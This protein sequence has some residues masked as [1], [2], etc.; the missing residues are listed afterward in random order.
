MKTLGSRARFAA[1]G[2]LAVLLLAAGASSPL[3]AEGYDPMLQIT[4]QFARPNIYLVVDVSGSMAWDIRG[5]SVGVDQTGTVPTAAWSSTR[6]SC[7]DSKCKVWTYTLTV[8]QTWPS[9][10]ATLKNALGDSVTIVTPWQEPLD[11]LTDTTYGYITNGSWKS[12]GTITGPTV[13]HGASTHTYKWTVTY[14]SHKSDPGEPF[15]IDGFPNLPGASGGVSQPPMNLIGKSADVVNWGLI[16]FSGSNC[17]TQTLQVAIDSNDTGVVTGIMNKMRLHSAGGL[18]ANGSTPTRGALTYAKAQLQNTF[19]A[20]PK[21]NCGRTYGVI[22]VTDGLSNNCNPSNK[23]WID[24]CGDPPYACDAGSSG[25]DCDKRNGRSRNYTAFPAGIAEQIWNLNLSKNG[26][27]PIKV[28]TWVIGVSDAVSRCELNFNAYMGRTDADSPNG[29]AGFDT[30]HDP[31]LPTATG[32]ESHYTINSTHKNY[33]YFAN[34]SAALRNAFASIVA[35]VATGDY[36]TS[37]PVAS[38]TLSAGNVAMLA[39]AEFPTWKG[40][41][42]CFDIN[43]VSTPKWDAGQVLASTAASARKL[44]TWDASNN[45]VEIKSSNLST[46]KTIAGQFTPSF[47]TARLTDAVVD[48]IRG[49]NG[50]GSDRAWKLGPIINSTPAIVQAP[51]EYKKGHVNDHTQFESDYKDRTPLVWIGSNDG[52]LHAF[53]VDN[54]QEVIALLPPNL[55]ADQ[56]DL[57]ANYQANP[58]DNPVGQPKMPADH[59]YT[60]ANHP[61]YADV[62]FG[63]PINGWRTVLF[64]TEGPGGDLV[65]A[66]DVTDPVSTDKKYVPLKVLWTKTG[67]YPAALQVPG[68]KESWSVPAIGYTGQATAQGVIGSGRNPSSTASSQVAPSV[69]LFDPAN[70]TFTQKTLTNS[71]TTPLVG[72]QTYAASTIYSTTADA[73]YPDSLVDLGLQADL[74][75]RVWFLPSSSSYTPV[76]GIDATQKAG[77][78]QPLYYPAAVSGYYQ[79]SQGYDLYAFG[80]GSFYEKS[81]AVTGPNVGKSGYFQPSLYIVA[82][83]MN[84]SAATASQIVRIRIQDLYRPGSTTEKIGRR[85]QLTAPPMLFVPV[86]SDVQPLALFLVYDPDTADCAGTSY[87]VKV[88]FDVSGGVPQNVTSTT[89]EAGSGAGSGFAIAGSRVIV[90]R[91]GVGQGKKA[92]I[93]TV[94]GVNPSQGHGNPAPSWWRELK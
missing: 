3:A 89:Y 36:T 40:H 63:S 42:Y 55:L 87:I 9:R 83:E 82:K 10:M 45:L 22:L 29:D 78:M 19:N 4:H 59:L 90:A 8:T 30:A 48:F 68:L 76:V 38:S 23:N 2:A 34:T 31:Y 66:L 33:A 64:L 60:V 69:F 52:F 85:A 75:G 49:G 92:T 16:T 81:E 26:S 18:D 37:A 65:A 32:D 61:R 20:D 7:S 27:P 50:S 24:P 71:G 21:Y 11:W 79:G 94:P 84:A 70:G 25:Y 43:N 86:Q 53:R 54:G 15:S 57:F 56:A 41:L 77:A 1:L 67:S 5:S 73:Y 47:D 44:Y 12:G 17:T 91:S 39:S 88:T 80:S 62:Y 6:S 93:E 14:N 46:L 51:E 13:T 74:N 28:R 35:A 72:N 58:T